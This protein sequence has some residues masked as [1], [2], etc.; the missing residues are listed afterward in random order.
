MNQQPPS[1]PP[2]QQPPPPGYGPPPPGQPPPGYGPPPMG[3][4]PEVPN[5]LVWSIL[6][7]L[8]CCLPFGIVAIIYAAQVNTKLAVG[9][10]PGAM[11]ASKNAKTWCWVSFGIGLAVGV[12]YL[13]VMIAGGVTM[14]SY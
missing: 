3:P 1:Q 7:T 6:T 11:E 9:D 8:F 12:I 4:R 13:I 2:P 14:S 5:Y 10:V